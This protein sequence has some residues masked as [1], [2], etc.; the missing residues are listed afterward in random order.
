MTMGSMPP[1][2]QL[3]LDLRP[4][5]IVLRL[6]IVNVAIW[7]VTAAAINFGG[8]GGFYGFL[9]DYLMVS[10]DGVTG[11]FYLWQPFTYMWLHDTQGLGHVLFNMLALFFLGPP[12]ERRWGKRTFV[13]FYLLSGVIAGV[14]SVL[15]GL[16]IPSWFGM[17]TL[18]ASG[19]ILALLAAF[20]MV[21]PNAEVLLFFVVPIRA[22]YIIWIAIGIDLLMFFASNPAT[23]TLGVHTHIGGA[24]GAW[25]LITGNWRPRVAWAR[26]NRK[27]G[28]ASGGAARANKKPRHGLRV[29]KGGRSD[30]DEPPKYLH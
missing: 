13:K 24:V 3:R 22:R 16:M 18:G 1:G 2:G 21:L 27:V 11:D 17:P 23:N 26:L 20:S 12:L 10:P 25:L 4:T 19:S 29:I 9:K 15:A 14:F 30:D 6:I 7:F 8:A 5:P 28:R